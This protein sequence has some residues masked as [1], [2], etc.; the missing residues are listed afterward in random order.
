M[1]DWRDSSLFGLFVVQKVRK[2]LRF[3]SHNK[4]FWK[5]TQ[6]L[7]LKNIIL[8]L[9]YIQSKSFFLEDGQ[10]ECRQ[11]NK[12]FLPQKKSKYSTT[13]ETEIMNRIS[14]LRVLRSLLKNHKSKKNLNTKS[15]RFLWG[16]FDTGDNIL[17]QFNYRKKEDKTNGQIA[18]D[19]SKSRSLNTLWLY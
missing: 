15:Q 6:L 18:Q 17:V 19:I 14:W 10:V 3:H 12:L 2:Y 1:S 8:T 16:L 9:R 4:V 5:E 13:S 7:S 11:K